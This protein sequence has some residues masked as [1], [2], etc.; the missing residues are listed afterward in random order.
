MKIENIKLSKNVVNFK[1]SLIVEQKKRL[2]E[3]SIMCEIIDINQ[4]KKLGK[5][6][7]GFYP[8]VWGKF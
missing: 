8:T 5:F 4:I 6:V 1:T 3:K 2:D 7:I